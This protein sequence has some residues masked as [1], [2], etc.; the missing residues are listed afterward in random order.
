[1]NFDGIRVVRS[2]FFAVDLPERL[3]DLSFPGLAFRL[4]RFRLLLRASQCG[5]EGNQMSVL[6][7]ALS[8]S[9][10]AAELLLPCLSQDVYGCCVFT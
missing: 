1:M 5:L 3:G 10:V 4:L 6:F 9:F 8:D 7:H 2:S